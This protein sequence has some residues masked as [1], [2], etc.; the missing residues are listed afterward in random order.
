MFNVLLEGLV[1]SSVTSLNISFS[2]A[3]KQGVTVTPKVFEQLLASMPA[4]IEELRIELPASVAKLP[5]GKLKEL[6]KLRSL[7]ISGSHLE[8]LPEDLP[9]CYSLTTLDLVSCK[10]LPALPKKIF[11]LRSLQHLNI[12]GCNS[13]MNIN[14]TGIAASPL[15][16]LLIED[17]IGLMNLPETVGNKFNNVKMLSVRGCFNLSAMPPWVAELEKDGAAVQRPYHLE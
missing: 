16:T 12:S 2:Q 15:E 6:P 1:E 10:A 5:D 3:V 17:C 7:F 4:T 14:A 8:K 13:I 9:E 11:D